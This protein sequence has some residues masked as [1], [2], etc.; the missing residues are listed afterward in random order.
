[1][2][3]KNLVLRAY[4]VLGGIADNG[5]ISAYVADRRPESHERL[6]TRLIPGAVQALKTSGLIGN[7]VR[8][9]RGQ[10]GIWQLTPAGQQVALTMFGN[11]AQ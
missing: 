4:Y 7:V 1:M 10:P 9:R 3:L 8:A 6:H 5:V 2:P 11:T